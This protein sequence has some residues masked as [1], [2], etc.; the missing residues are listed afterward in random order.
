MQ[1]KSLA[2]LEMMVR[3]RIWFGGDIFSASQASDSPSGYSYF[4]LVWFQAKFPWQEWL[5]STLLAVGKCT[6]LTRCGRFR[7]G[8]CPRR[9]LDSPVGGQMRSQ[10][11]LLGGTTLRKGHDQARGRDCSLRAQSTLM[12]PK[13]AQMAQ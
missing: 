5:I 6:F 1:V 10:A 2:E 4:P 3:W 8:I 11:S 9:P 7:R 13:D 12:G